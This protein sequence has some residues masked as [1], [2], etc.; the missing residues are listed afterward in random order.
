LPSIKAYDEVSSKKYHIN[1]DSRLI[2]KYHGTGENIKY[3]FFHNL[4]AL[5][6]DKLKQTKKPLSQVIPYFENLLNFKAGDIVFSYVDNFMD[7]GEKK[8]SEITSLEGYQIK[9][10]KII[11][12]NALNP[13]ILDNQISGFLYAMETLLQLQIKHGGINYGII[14]D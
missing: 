11:T 13:R 7:V 10:D 8:Y 12:I 9:I 2:M 5:C 1:D 3:D 14:T 6:Y 4:S